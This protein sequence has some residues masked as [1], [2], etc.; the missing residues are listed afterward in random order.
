MKLWQNLKGMTRSSKDAWIGGVCGGLGAATP[1]PSWMWRAAFLFA[2]LAYGVGS[3]LYI[4]L[5]ICLPD[6]PE[7][8]QGP[9]S[10]CADCASDPGTARH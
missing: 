5:W 4:V 7:T 8:E 10:S 2:L 3:L 9:C 1:L 6:E